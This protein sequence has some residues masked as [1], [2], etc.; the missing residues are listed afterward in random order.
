MMGRMA[1]DDQAVALRPAATIVVVRS[2]GG[3]VEV[4]VLRRSLASP[5][6]PGFVVFPGGAIDA[7]DDALAARWFGTPDERARACAIREL[8]EEA[9]LVLSRRGV[10]PAAAGS[11]E[12]PRFDP[13]AREQLPQI[14]RWIAPEFMPVRFDAWFFA[15]RCPGGI[16]PTVDGTEVDAAW[17]AWPA[18]V[19]DGHRAGQVALAWPTLKTVEALAA[20]ASVRDVLDLR[21]EQA[22]PADARPGGGQP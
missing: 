10:E 6:V 19:L 20:C 17:W 4:L 11:F 15:A 8:G 9:G 16:E 1:P 14:G 21:I 18:D 2:A 3:G 13:P 22:S 5:F 12:S 7:G